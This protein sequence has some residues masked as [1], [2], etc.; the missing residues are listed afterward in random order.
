MKTIKNYL[1]FIRTSQTFMK[2]SKNLIIVFFKSLYKGIHFCK[3]QNEWDSEVEATSEESA[4]ARL[5]RNIEF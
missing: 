4:Y 2:G 5:N 3:L 1:W